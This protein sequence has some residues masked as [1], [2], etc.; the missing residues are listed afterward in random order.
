MS[1][2]LIVKP[3]AHA[4][5]AD[6]EGHYRQIGEGL[7]DRF[8]EAVEQTLKRIVRAP[9]A[10]AVDFMAARKAHVRDFPFLIVFRVEGETVVVFGLFHERRDPELWHARVRDSVNGN[11]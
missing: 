3:E 10:Y 1:Y 7:A 11:E 9:L 4:D 6:Q 8:L 5:I 2:T